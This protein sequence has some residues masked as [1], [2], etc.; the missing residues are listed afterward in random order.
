MTRD[1]DNQA[2]EPL[3]P[4]P[5][6]VEAKP[7][8][9]FKASGTVDQTLTV[10]EGTRKFWRSTT[11]I[12][13]GVLLTSILVGLALYKLS[14]LKMELAILDHD[15]KIHGQ[16]TELKEVSLEAVYRFSPTIQPPTHGQIA[17]VTVTVF[18][19]HSPIVNPESM[20]TEAA[21]QLLGAAV[22]RRVHAAIP[23]YLPPHE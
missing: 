5:A 12:G 7:D 22:E 8:F 14:G 13:A 3:V 15:V 2:S 18:T 11:F 17:T 23:A 19:P 6:N 9:F 21:L 1:E 4:P 20:A 16:D 10:T